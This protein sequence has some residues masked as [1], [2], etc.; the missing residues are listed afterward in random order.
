MKNCIRFSVFIFVSAL[1]VFIMCG[2]SNQSAQTDGNYD[3]RIILRSCEGITIDGDNIIDTK[4]GRSATFKVTINDGYIYIGNNQN[5]EYNEETGKLRLTN[6]IAPATVDML[7]VKKEDALFFNTYSNN[8]AACLSVTDKILAKPDS[9]TV[10]A[11]YPEHLQ[12]A[13]WSEGG[14]LSEGGKLIST[15]EEHTFEV[16]NSMTVYANFDGYTEYEI[17]Y[18][19]NGGHVRTSSDDIYSVKAEYNDIYAMQ[20]TLESNG[21]FVRDG[22]VAVGY[23]D[24]PCEYG[25]Y[26]SANDIDGFSNMGGVTSVM[27]KSRDLY[28]V[29]AKETDIDS[30]KYESKDISYIKDSSY[31]FG[32]LSQRKAEEKGIEI[33][34]YT[35]SGDL[36]VIP[37]QIDGLP[38]MSIAADAFD[39]DM[40]RVVI[41][42]TVKN[43]A[44]GAF[45]KCEK[46][47]E[48]VFFDSVVTVYNKSF[49]KNV[50]TVVLNAQR[51]PVYSGAIEGSF[52]IKY[53][54]L[55]KTESK[56][57]VV[58]SGSSSLNGLN[59]P[60]LEELVPGYSVINYGTNV[61]NPALFFLEVISKYVSEGDIVIHAPEYSS[62][63]SMGSNSFHAKV[64]RGNEQCYDIFRDVD[65]SHYSD[66]WESFCEFQV[67]DKNDGSLVPAI[68]QSGK[69]YQLDTEINKYGDRSTVRK[70]VRG[71][72]G[73]PS[74]VFRYNV[75]NEKN[76]N[77]VNTL[78]IKKGAVLAMSFGTFDKSRLSS[79]SAVQSEYDK[80]TKYCADKLDYPVIS[81]IG[82]YVME[83]KYFFDSEW[84]TN[85]E[86]ARIRTTNLADDIN[87]YLRDPS[88][89]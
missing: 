38:V 7:V 71:N 62:H 19:L 77:W 51:L 68:H 6:I 81:N 25:D 70:S 11:E 63:T 24:N 82:T 12:F 13:G 74:E 4:S 10:K 17:I 86:G 35:G 36:V 28:V 76:L 5:A 65:I 8:P 29:W 47:R 64:F 50:E 39:S 83:H 31:G 46:L 42:R 23:S 1:L 80:F 67:G 73:S 40:E 22:Y 72:F 2:C 14:Y 43:I 41:P 18:H 56:K 85:D 69:P 60:L 54:R 27:G 66:F 20:Q 49:N 16:E 84:H 53:E 3:V 55:R 48:V 15:D 21:I 57:I 87:A 32:S 9:I 58:V 26:N 33:T 52:C 59:S 44:S 37:E 75:L 88:K 45:S 30:F 79:S 34:G 89:Y 61:A 78:Y